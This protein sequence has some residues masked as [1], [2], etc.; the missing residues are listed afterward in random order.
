MLPIGTSK[1]N[2]WPL[3]TENIN[4]KIVNPKNSF[5]SIFFLSVSYMFYTFV[6]TERPIFSHIPAKTLYIDYLSKQTLSKLNI[7]FS[8]M[9][10]YSQKNVAMTCDTLGIIQANTSK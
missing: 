7:Y 8:T 10:I 2:A 5:L 9:S 6:P 4:A 3:A 1:A